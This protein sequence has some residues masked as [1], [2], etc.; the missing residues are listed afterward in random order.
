MLRVDLGLNAQDL[1]R[2]VGMYVL[3]FDA[4]VNAHGHG[5]TR[6]EGDCKCEALS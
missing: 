3:T 5:G 2:Y 6:M 1:L 4:L